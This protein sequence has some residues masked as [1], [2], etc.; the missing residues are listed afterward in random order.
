MVA[1]GSGISDGNRHNHDDLPVLLAGG[2]A[3]Y[4]TGKHVR[5]TTDTPVTN[6]YLSMLDRMGVEVEKLGDSA[7]RL[8]TLSELA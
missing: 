6:L 5:F 2:S 8:E 3:M 7:G 1:Y 4:R